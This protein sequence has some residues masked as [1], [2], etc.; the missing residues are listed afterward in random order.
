[1][2]ILVDITPTNIEFLYNGKV[3]RINEIMTSGENKLMIGAE[4]KIQQSDSKVVPT[5]NEEII[6]E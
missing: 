3:Y 4:E 2:P 6:P 1:M 5:D